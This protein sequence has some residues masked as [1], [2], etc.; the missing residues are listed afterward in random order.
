MFKL[1]SAEE[2]IENWFGDCE[3]EKEGWNWGSDVAKGVSPS[4]VKCECTRRSLA[5]SPPFS[6]FLGILSSF[7][8]SFWQHPSLWIWGNTFDKKLGGKRVE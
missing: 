6:P 3:V 4:L 2:L 7:Y 5:E 8:F 1:C